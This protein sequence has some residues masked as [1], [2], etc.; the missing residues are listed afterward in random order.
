M[1]VSTS[2]TAG[3]AITAADVNAIAALANTA[4]AGLIAR[5]AAVVVH[6]SNAAYARP[7]HSGPVVWIGTVEPAGLLDGDVH[8]AVTALP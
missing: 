6:G 1:A 7:A 4:E 2:H 3:Q 5:Q 8:I